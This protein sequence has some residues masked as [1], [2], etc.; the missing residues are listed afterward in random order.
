MSN[1][2]A[3][4]VSRS[5]VL[6]VAAI[7]LGLLAYSL[8]GCGDDSDH[9]ASTSTSTSAATTGTPTTTTKTSPR[10][11][12]PDEPKSTVRFYSRHIVHG[13]KGRATLRPGKKLVSLSVSS[14]VPDR[15]FTMFIY[16]H[17]GH[18][19]PIGQGLYA[20]HVSQ[21]LHIPLARLAKYRYLGLVVV[22]KRPARHHHRAHRAI[23]VVAR[24]SVAALINGLLRQHTPPT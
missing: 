4:L 23:R 10:A 14:T 18:G 16:T 12:K 8:I 2:P 11:S 13:V 17:R 24:A 9:V 6:A 21:T 22:T 15:R 3:P 7:A 5:V 19:I 20:G 1:T